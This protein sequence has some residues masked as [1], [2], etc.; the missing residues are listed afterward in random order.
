AAER[1]VL[2]A[3]GNR[4][5]MVTVKRRIDLELYI[6]AAE[7]VFI[8]A[9]RKVIPCRKALSLNPGQPCRSKAAR[10]RTTGLDLLGRFKNFRPGLWR[11]VFIK[12]GLLEGVL[13][14]IE[15]RRRGVIW[16]GQ[17]GAIGL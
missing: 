7:T 14:V 8:G 10:C 13:V 15:D 3:T 2:C 17:H 9:I 1:A 12:T 16:E 11:I 4:L 5:E 6:G